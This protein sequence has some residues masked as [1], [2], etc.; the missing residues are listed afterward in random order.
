MMESNEVLGNMK[1]PM[2]HLQQFWPH[3][4]LL[5]GF[6][7]LHRHHSSWHL[8]PLRP[9]QH[10]AA[11]QFTLHGPPLRGCCRL[12]AGGCF[13]DGNTDFY[14]ILFIFSPHEASA[15]CPTGPSRG[16]LRAGCRAPAARRAAA[17]RSARRPR[18]QRKET[19]LYFLLARVEINHLVYYFSLSLHILL[20]LLLFVRCEAVM[21]PCRPPGRSQPASFVWTPL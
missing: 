11:S 3:R 8:A 13:R 10:L 4:F 7:Y 6:L 20:L 2:K 14:F 16:L 1:H 18:R 9:L 12:A 5:K 21:W 15:G 19:N 17:P